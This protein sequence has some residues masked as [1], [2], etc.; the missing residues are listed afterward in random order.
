[1]E[2]VSRVPERLKMTEVN[3]REGVE[4]GGNQEVKREI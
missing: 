1:V 2:G 3:A 4:R